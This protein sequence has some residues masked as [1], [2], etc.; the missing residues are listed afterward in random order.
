MSVA[1]PSEIDPRWAS[2]P[3]VTIKKV[4]DSR[5]LS[6]EDLAEA[7]DISDPEA[8]RVLMG[9]RPITPAIATA[10]AGLLGSTRQFWL[11][12]ESQYRE[13]LSWLAA[14]ELVE[15]SPVR[16]MERDGWIDR[17]DG[18]KDQAKA[19]LDFYGVR[20][21]AEWRAIWGPR[22]AET[23]FRTSVAFESSELAVAA[24]LRRVELDAF[25]LDV[26]DWSPSLLWAALPRLRALSKV[27][28]PRSFIPV[29]ERLLG[30]A[31]VAV[32]V[33]RAMDGNRLSG[34][35]SVLADGR[36]A[37]GL[38]ARHLSDDH[39]WFTLFHEIGHL[40]LHDGGGDF[41]DDFDE[42]ADDSQLEGQANEFARDAL[43]PGGVG[44]LLGRRAAGPTMRQ[45]V[46]FASRLGVAPGIVVGRLHYDGVLKYNQ[47]RTLIRGYKWDGS[48]LRT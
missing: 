11:T 7:L 17:S 33:I 44:D 3:G 38:T 14:D 5:G 19:L 43:I 23:R 22:L 48:T 34:A 27:R 41:L 10:L 35:A 4:L 2:A 29:L 20:D 31:G 45:V 21:A 42:V 46:S 24:W 9:A 6:A 47:L 26:A 25:E 30:A 18:W 12:R 32:V 16:A 28:D 36:R 1:M 39:F 8:R 37:I 15:R 13:S 40:L